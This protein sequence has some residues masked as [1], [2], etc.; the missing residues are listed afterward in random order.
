MVDF[1]CGL[2][3]T[4]WARIHHE[5]PT[6]ITPHTPD[7]YQRAGLYEGHQNFWLIQRAGS[8]YRFWNYSHVLTPPVDGQ[9]YDEMLEVAVKARWQAQHLRQQAETLLEEAARLDAVACEVFNQALI[10]T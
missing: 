1:L 4:Q 5:P 10:G 2:T 8:G 7:G 3:A 9:D 6:G